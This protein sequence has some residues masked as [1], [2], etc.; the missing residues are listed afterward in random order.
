MRLIDADALIERWTANGDYENGI[1]DGA[2][3]IKTFEEAPTIKPRPRGKWIRKHNV[4]GAVY[5]S[6]CDYELHT[7]DTNFC[8][9]CGAD[10]REE[11]Q[12]E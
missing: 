11:E 7:N 2:F 10:M 9:N 8:P 1:Y 5:C 4:H 6:L 3:I 12:D